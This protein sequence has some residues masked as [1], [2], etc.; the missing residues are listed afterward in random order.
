MTFLIT[1]ILK[2]YTIHLP[3]QIEALRIDNMF[4]HQNWSQILPQ[5]KNLGNK[6]IGNFPLDLFLHQLSSD[7][8][9][10]IFPLS[11]IILLAPIKDCIECEKLFK[12]KNYFFW[13]EEIPSAYDKILNQFNLLKNLLSLYEAII[14]KK[15]ILL[16]PYEVLGCFI[17]DISYVKDNSLLVKKED[18]LSQKDFS[19]KLTHLG[20]SPG[21]VGKL[22]EG[23]FHFRGEILDLM[24]YSSKQ[25]R[26]TYFDDLIEHIYPYDSSMLRAI[27]ENELESVFIIPNISFFLKP[28]KQ[29]IARDKIP[30]PSPQF[31]QKYLARKEFFE[32]LASGQ[33]PPNLFFLIHL[34][35]NQSS[36]LFEFF[37]K[38]RYSCLFYEPQIGIRQIDHLAYSERNRF[39]EESLL[40][41]QSF[42]TPEFNKIYSF[43]QLRNEVE[44]APFLNFQSYHLQLLADL[45]FKEDT[46]SK[47]WKRTSKLEKLL[48]WIKENFDSIQKIVFFLSNDQ[49]KSKLSTVFQERLGPQFQK[50][51][52]IISWT[53][54]S[55]GNSYFEEFSQVLLIKCSDF[56]YAP[57][58]NNQKKSKKKIDF[59][60]EHLATLH[61][62]D[63]VVHQEL[64]IGKFQGLQNMTVGGINSDFIVLHYIGEDKVYIPVYKINLLQK[65]ADG[66]AK[67]KLSDLRSK[68]FEQEK[69]KA[70]QSVKKLAFDLLRL[71]AERKS[72]KGFAFSPPDELFEEFEKSFPYEET[73]DQANAIQD[74]LND[75]CSP[76]PMDRLICGDVGFGKTEVAMR[77][78][79]KA[80]LDKKQ[81]VILVPTTILCLQHYNNFK[82]RLG[83]FGVKVNYLSRL[84][85]PKENKETL[86]KIEDGN[87]DVVIATHKILS[88]KIKFKDLG[89]VIV[90]EEQR[91]GVGDKEKLKLLRSQLDYL[92]LTATPIPRTL[93][94]AFLGIRSL[95]LIQTPP[96]DRLS[97][98]SILISEDDAT[99]K[100]AIE[101]E[102]DR[103]GQIFYINNKVIDIEILFGKIHKLVPRARIVV[104]HGQLQEN[105]LAKKIQ[106]FYQKKY[107]LLLA[108]TIVESGIDVPTANTMIINNAH[109]YGLSQLHQL[110]GRIGRSDR[111]AYCYFVTPVDKKLSENSTKRLESLQ[112]YCDLGSGFA[113]S[114]SDLEIRGAGELLGA[115]QSGQIQS[116]GLELYLDLLKEAM[117][118]I[119]GEK[120]EV[121]NHVDI[122]LGQPAYIP[123]HFIPDQAARL[124]FYKKLSNSRSD[125]EIDSIT[126]DL[127]EIYGTL[128][129]SVDNLIVTI[130]ARNYLS[131]LGVSLLSLSKSGLNIKFNE[132]YLKNIPHISQKILSYFLARPKKF[133]FQSS[134]SVLYQSNTP[135]QIGEVKEFCRE[136][137]DIIPIT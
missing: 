14:S 124:K 17:P 1:F 134:Y 89:L 65:Y 64:G 39:A 81:V 57:I 33:L 114:N 50:I 74:V 41:N 62:G 26:F 4:L 30:I 94:M 122:Q 88:G 87:C 78:T 104:A 107:D 79:F 29:T 105:D 135:I 28:E 102:L 82:E 101:L 119:K 27:R 63:F 136:L 10:K 12:N 8:S 59:F 37:T 47:D 91:F 72:Q 19:E 46:L 128:P 132:D 18:I 133:K 61:E 54:T 127:V 23:E 25:F 109:A 21:I 125:E 9:N 70:K 137:S 112:R 2:G 123:Q 45:L 55:I 38:E 67:V 130:Y 35:F 76:I 13:T 129:E 24:T 116:V 80:V 75:M 68:K 126:Q 86:I 83:A 131:K 77:A 90:D 16:L 120:L 51:F 118:E 22:K 110:R 98:K 58:G 100:N 49:E 5:F 20:Y 85:T 66:D 15:E 111:K 53:D 95:S 103:G 92:T 42:L 99:I 108:T 56:I 117:E 113:L 52:S 32:E 96:S 31:R 36:T 115:E 71:E 69:V 44:K 7:P 106:D 3:L 97:V 73:E 40:E 84:S 11:P 34:F 6:S 60:A 121:W 43:D 93:Q 48:T